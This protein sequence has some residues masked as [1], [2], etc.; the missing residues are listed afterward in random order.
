MKVTLPHFPSVESFWCLT[1]CNSIKHKKFDSVL[2]ILWITVSVNVIIFFVLGFF[3]TGDLSIPGNNGLKDQTAALKWIK[4]NI[5]NFGGNPDSVTIM[6]CSAGGASVHYHF[7]SPL[8]E[9][10]LFWCIYFEFWT[11]VQ[12]NA[13]ELLPWPFSVLKILHPFEL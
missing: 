5:R 12:K 9:G 6:G 7:L 13:N 4:R 2:N 11:F 8:S 3:S 1:M 10:K